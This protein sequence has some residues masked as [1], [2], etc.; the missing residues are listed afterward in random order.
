MSELLKDFELRLK[1][2]KTSYE[3][4]ALLIRDEKQKLIQG[5]STNLTGFIKSFGANIIDVEIDRDSDY[6]PEVRVTIKFF[7]IRDYSDEYIKIT[8]RDNHVIYD[9]KLRNRIFMDSDS[10]IKCIELLNNLCNNMTA[11]RNAFILNYDKYIELS[12]VFDETYKSILRLE[13]SIN[14]LQ[15]S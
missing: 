5:I 14:K 4:H 12:K 13:H 8:Y 9:Y 1:H 2:L 7:E 10:T 11:V 6:K 15:N 3:T